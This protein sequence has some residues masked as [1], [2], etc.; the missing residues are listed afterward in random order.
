MKFLLLCADKPLGGGAGGV[1]DGVKNE[2]KICPFYLSSKMGS[3]F[4][5]AKNRLGTFLV[6]EK[7][8]KGAL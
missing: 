5:A 2:N 3:T 1:Q 7:T 8:S 4:V 6:A